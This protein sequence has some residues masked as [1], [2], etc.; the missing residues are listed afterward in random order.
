MPGTRV[1]LRR[2]EHKPCA[3]HPRLLCLGVGKTWMAGTSPAMT[4]L[5]E[6]NAFRLLSNIF[7]LS[8]CC[9][10]AACK[11]AKE[12]RGN[13]ER[14]LALYSECVPREVREFVIDLMIS[15]ELGYS[16]EEAMRR[17]KENAKVFF[18]RNNSCHSGR[19]DKCPYSS[20]P[21][22]TRQSIGPFSLSRRFMDGRIKS[23]HDEVREVQ[24]G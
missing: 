14:C 23:G 10:R 5:G 9:D 15:R 20:L 16:F 4:N 11:R 22:L 21:G 7:S 8:Q 24:C 2:P 13:A 1:R 18:A 19:A 17:D 6:R 12:C 3:G